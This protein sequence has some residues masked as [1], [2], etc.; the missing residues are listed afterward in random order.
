[1][2]VPFKLWVICIVGVT[3]H[4]NEISLKAYSDTDVDK[5][6]KICNIYG[7]QL[8]HSSQ[9]YFNYSVEHLPSATSTYPLATNLLLH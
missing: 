8:Q 1:M 4:C 2:R 5:H 6:K 9:H 3:G 7:D